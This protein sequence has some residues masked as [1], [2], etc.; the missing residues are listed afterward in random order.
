MDLVI[1]NGIVV[2]PL[3]AY[4]AEIGVAGGR[5]VELAEKLEAGSARVLDARGGFVLPGLVD[6]H[7]HFGAGGTDDFGSGTREALAGGVTTVVDCAMQA[8]GQTLTAALEARRVLAASQSYADYT[9]HL[10]VTEW[11]E[12][13][14]REVRELVGS[15]HPSFEFHQTG[16]CL[17]DL[18]ALDD[19]ALFELLQE[20]AKLGATVV[21]RPGNRA[22]SAV[23]ASQLG[24]DVPLGFEKLGD[25]F[26]AALEAEGIRRALALADATDANL[27]VGPLSSREAV[28]ALSWGRASGVN[29]AGE[30]SPHYLLP[31]FAAGAGV[32]GTCRPPVRTEEDALALWHAAATGDVEVIASG[33]RAPSRQLK[34]AVSDATRLEAGFPSIAWTLPLLFSEGFRQS[35]VTLTRLVQL[36]STNPAMLLGMFPAKGILQVGSDADLVVL[37]P[38]KECAVSL[39]ANR[40]GWDHT[41]YE[42][43]VLRGTPVA[44]VLGGAVVFAEGELTG[45][46]GQGKLVHRHPLEEVY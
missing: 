32:L 45:K 1:K 41:P 15:G 31:H 35:H 4:P 12:A 19:A 36:L 46:P 25:V 43:H 18:P 42:G 6:L 10:T 5:I 21:L 27:L 39:A 34:T 40:A 11:N 17:L 13:T 14:R 33:H 26:T 22:A 23:L 38:E 7:T 3:S 44:T 20:T 30:T 29:A 28:A 16:G 9:F 24:R 8:P 2:G 37:D